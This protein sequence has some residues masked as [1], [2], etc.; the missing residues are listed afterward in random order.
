V[1]NDKIDRLRAVGLSR[2]ADRAA[3]GF[4]PV[5]RE[6]FRDALSLKEFGISGLDQ[7]CQDKFFGKGPE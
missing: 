1:N 3:L 4:C 6:D 5:A 7:K 2:G